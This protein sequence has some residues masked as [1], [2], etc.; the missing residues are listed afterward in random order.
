M[1]AH[2]EREVVEVR[3][4]QRDRERRRAI[5]GASVREGTVVEG[6]CNRGW[7]KAEATREKKRSNET[8]DARATSTLCARTLEAILI[9]IG[10]GAWCA[11]MAVTPESQGLNSPSTE[12]Q[13]GNFRAPW[14]K[15]FVVAAPLL[16]G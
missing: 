14:L 8:L 11:M 7:V 3:A 13:W 1:E 12:D 6:V 5:G 16:S 2:S 10:S 9:S 15:G 4:R